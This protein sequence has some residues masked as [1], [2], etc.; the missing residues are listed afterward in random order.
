MD[1]GPASET[2]A[3]TYLQHLHQSGQLAS[4]DGG[5][6]DFSGYK[7]KDGVDNGGFGSLPLD[8]ILVGQS[9]VGLDACSSS[10]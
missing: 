2:F 8:S 1:I 9:R 4:V 3:R 10:S 7:G 6:W 5:R